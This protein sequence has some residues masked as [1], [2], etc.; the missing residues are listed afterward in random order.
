MSRTVTI[1]CALGLLAAGGFAG[2]PSAAAAPPIAGYIGQTASSVAGCPFLLWRLAKHAN[3][4]ITGLVYY[5]DLGGI[6]MAK[7]NINQ[8]GQ[9]HIELTSALGDGPV[10]TIEGKKPGYGKATAVMKG[11]GCANAELKMSP[12]DNLNLIP[13]AS[14]NAYKGG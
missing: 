8:S 11:A 10:A 9:F 14:Q 3:G 6:S 5:S 7:G 4:S 12:V 13:S 2:W 1:C